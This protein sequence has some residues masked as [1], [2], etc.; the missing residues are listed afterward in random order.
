MSALLSFTPKAVAQ[1]DQWHEVSVQSTAVFTKHSEGNGITQRTTDSGG[2]LVNYRFHFNSWLA[3]EANYGYSRNTH[4]YMTVGGPF[5]EQANAHQTTGALVVTLPSRF[6][7]IEPYVLGGAGAVTFDPR[8]G[9]VG[10]IGGARK[11][12]KAAFVYGGGANFILFPKVSLR[13]EY[14][15]LVYK[16]P[17]FGL[18]LLNTNAVT[19]S[20]Q[21]SVGFSFRF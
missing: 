15:G 17:Y 18:S 21:P 7:R 6:T 5:G 12:T 14:R 4:R 19:H 20:A 16:Q 1:E 10:T 11:E 3:A 8:G 2:L 9:E 13:V